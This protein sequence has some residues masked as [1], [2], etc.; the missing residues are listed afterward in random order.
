MKLISNCKSFIDLLSSS[1]RS[2]PVELAILLYAF[3]VAS[4]HASNQ[5]LDFKVACQLVPMFVALAFFVRSTIKGRWGNCLYYALPVIMFALWLIPGVRGWN[6]KMV[7]YQVVTFGM[8]PLLLLLRHYPHRKDR[9][10]SEQCIQTAWT[11]A[12]SSFF[13]GVIVLLGG[14][15]FLSIDEIFETE[16]MN[17][18]FIQW[19]YKF[20]II[21]LWPMMF[22]SFEGRQYRKLTI[23]GFLSVAVNYILTPAILVYTAVLYIYVTSILIQWSLPKGQVAIMVFSFVIVAMLAKMLVPFTEKKFM[24]WFYDHF[25]WF[26]LPL[27]LLFWI[28]SIRRVCDY[29]VTESRYYLLCFGALMTFYVVLFLFRR[30]KKRY[31]IVVLSTFIVLLVTICVP[32]ISARQVSWRSQMGIARTAAQQLGR[33]DEDGL[34]ILTQ[35]DVGDTVDVDQHRKVYGA[36]VYLEQA[37]K[38]RMRQEFGINVSEDYL[39]TLSSNAQDLVLKERDYRTSSSELY[40]YAGDELEIVPCEGGRY[41]VCNIQN[42]RNL[43]GKCLQ[44]DY[45][46]GSYTIE[47]DSLVATQ[48]RKCGYT[49][50]LLTKTFLDD[51]KMDLLLY[52]DDKVVVKIDYMSILQKDG[53]IGHGNVYVNFAIVK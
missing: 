38:D 45:G 6:M 48:L 41:V 25:S 2:H 28:G 32:N 44:I 24:G 4:F 43:H 51:H 46:E 35:P 34:L 21:I 22:V 53:V 27:L 17:S 49:G 18:L 20:V 14:L 47:V 15:I 52:E 31:F 3:F 7:S 1:T 42:T 30:M 33:L 36:L 26:A 39:N 19:V 50:G 40:I 11:A 37:D 29:G 9:P 16:I 23:R 13:V 10:F 5:Y 12:L 8:I